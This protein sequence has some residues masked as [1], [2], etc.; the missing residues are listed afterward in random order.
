[1]NKVFIVTRQTSVDGV[2]VE[3]VWSTRELA[4]SAVFYHAHHSNLLYAQYHI[5]EREVDKAHK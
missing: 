3:S 1:M 5:I 4:E 2:L